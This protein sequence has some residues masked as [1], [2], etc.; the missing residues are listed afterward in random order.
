MNNTIYIFLWVFFLCFSCTSSQNK[1]SEQSLPVPEI[2]ENINKIKDTIVETK[3]TEKLLEKE[4]N[5]KIK[6][7]P[8]ANNWVIDTMIIKCPENFRDDLKRH[9][10]FKRK[11]WKDVSNPFIATYKGNYFGDYPYI[12]FEE[13]NGKTHDFGF[14]NNDLKKSDFSEILLY[15]ESQMSDTLK[16]FNKSFN[17]FW[18]WKASKFYCCTGGYVVVEAYLP[19]LIKLEM[20]GN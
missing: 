1:N 6:N 16:Y 8:E 17:V 15:E 13:S 19:S 20:I 18:D 9:L 3:T 14:G 10:E 11:Q 5:K 4:S 2:S 12:I 7:E